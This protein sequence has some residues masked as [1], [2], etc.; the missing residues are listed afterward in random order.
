MPDWQVVVFGKRSGPGGP[1]KTRARARVAT[2]T[3]V[4]G[5][6][7]ERAGH[8]R[9][10]FFKSCPARLIP[11]PVTG[12]GVARSGYGGPGGPVRSGSGS[13]FFFFSVFFSVFFFFLFSGF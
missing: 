3:G 8:P 2:G 7:V 10:F 4:T 11:V 12:S 6:R 5:T 13:G 9:V 1:G